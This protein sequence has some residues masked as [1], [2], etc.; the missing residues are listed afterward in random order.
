MLLC[1]RKYS[2]TRSYSSIISAQVA[3]YLP[4]GRPFIGQGSLHV[5]FFLAKWVTCYQKC[6]PC[7]TSW[8]FMVLPNTALPL[9]RRDNPS[10]VLDTRVHNYPIHRPP[11]LPAPPW[12]Y[13]IAFCDD[14]PMRSWADEAAALELDPYAPADDDDDFADSSPATTCLAWRLC[15]S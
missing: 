7:M 6:S 12:E 10:S 11:L 2:T 3:S 13:R 15:W 9:I 1:I 4:P 5:L 8:C 14:N